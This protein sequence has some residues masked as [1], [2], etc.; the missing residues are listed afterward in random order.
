VLVIKKLVLVVIPVVVIAGIFVLNRS[1]V[2]ESADSL[3]RVADPLPI[4]V[5][6]ASPQQRELVRVVQGPGEVEP[7]AEVDISSEVV[8]KIVEMAV[9]EGDWVQE[10]DLICRLDDADY[11]ARVLSRE[12]NVAKLRAAIVQAAADLAKAER[13]YERQEGLRAAN[14]TSP[15]E[16]AD[17]QTLLVGA[18]AVL[19]MRKQE[20]VESEAAL[21]SARE[22]LAKTVI[23]APIA[24][25]VSQRFAKE[26]EVV[27]TGTMNNPGTRILVIS[28]LSEMQVR[29]RI[30]ETDAALVEPG[31]DARI[32]LQSDTRRSIPGTVERVATKGTKPAGRDVVTFETLILITGEDPRVKPGMTA[33]V[34]IEV[35]RRPDALTVPIEA[36]VYRKRRDLPESLV[37][38]QDQ[39]AAEED[40]TAR[41]HMAE[42]LKIVFCIADDKA[43]ARLV[44]TGISDPTRV[45][46]L[47]GIVP[48]DVVVTGPYRSL[49]QLKD[50][51]PVK[52][53]EKP[54]GGAAADTKPAG[55][56]SEPVHAASGGEAESK[57]E[58]DHNG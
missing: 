2:G 25:I 39:I 9:E 36:V 52:L 16:V 32:Y 5:E 1:R 26:G 33:N 48:T 58:A 4:E 15:L 20:L 7:Y 3:L 40:P 45:E 54:G 29:C 14:A 37:A 24:G 35:D 21:Q 12:A 49:D 18:Q 8:G 44:R 51:S 47:S 10:G 23:K 57:G 41:Q 43:H 11:R 6:T 31:Q 55:E 19:E 30:D 13:D 27:V 53:A 28:D 38:E 22:D 42:Y 34:E 56:G 46:V 17:C 50:E